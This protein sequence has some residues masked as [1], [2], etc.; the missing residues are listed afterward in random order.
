MI[1]EDVSQLQV[2]VAEL[3]AKVQLLA[4]ALM[5]TQHKSFLSLVPHGR[6]I[7][8]C[9]KMGLDEAGREML[10]VLFEEK[11]DDDKGQQSGPEDTAG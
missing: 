8:L 3:R 10:E 9:T 4:G 2:E 6:F 5:Y 11:K 1:R 7:A